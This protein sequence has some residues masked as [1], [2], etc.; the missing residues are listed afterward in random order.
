MTSEIELNS[1][2]CFA[3]RLRTLMT[4]H[5]LTVRKAG[6]IAGVSSSVIQSWLSRSAPRNLD[7]VARLAD[8]FNVDFRELLLGETEDENEEMEIS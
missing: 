4:R 7:A 1:D 2:D 5:C 3:H 6:K 8:Q